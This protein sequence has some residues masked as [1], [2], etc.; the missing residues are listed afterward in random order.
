MGDVMRFT[1]SRLFG[2]PRPVSPPLLGYA[3]A[4]LS[5]LHHVLWSFYLDAVGRDTHDHESCVPPI[6]VRSQHSFCSVV[7]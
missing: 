2:P 3:I 7:T 6:C 4:T 5:L 1:V